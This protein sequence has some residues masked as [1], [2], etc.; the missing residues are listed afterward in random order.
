MLS[1]MTGDFNKSD[2]L[3]TDLKIQILWDVMVCPT[4]DAIYVTMESNTQEDLIFSDIARYNL[5][6]CY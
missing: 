6:L 4:A 5:K 3:V 2:E 1:N